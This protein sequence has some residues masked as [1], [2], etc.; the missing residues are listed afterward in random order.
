MFF[1]NALPSSQPSG[2][3]RSYK[4]AHILLNLLNSMRK[5]EKM[6]SKTHILLLF[7]LL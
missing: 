1:S 6:L 2:L 5:I 7:Y 3:R 4:S